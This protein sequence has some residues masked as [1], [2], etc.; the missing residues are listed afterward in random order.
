M[1][2]NVSIFVFLMSTLYLSTYSL[3]LNLKRRSRKEADKVTERS[4]TSDESSKLRSDLSD[5]HSSTK[6]REK[7]FLFGLIPHAEPEHVNNK[8]SINLEIES[9]L[10]PMNEESQ[11]E[12]LR[13]QRINPNLN[14]KA[15]SQ[16]TSNLSENQSDTLENV[17]DLELLNSDGGH[18]VTPHVEFGVSSK[19]QDDPSLTKE[20]DPHMLLHVLLA[21]NSS[22]SEDLE[23]G[24]PS[25][26]LVD[27][28]L[29]G[30]GIPS[31]E[32]SVES[33]SALNSSVQ[34]NGIDTIS[35]SIDIENEGVVDNHPVKNYSSNVAAVSKTN[36]LVGKLIKS[37]LRNNEEKQARIG[38]LYG[39]EIHRRRRRSVVPQPM[40]GYLDDPLNLQRSYRLRRRRDTAGVGGGMGVTG[41][42]LDRLAM[43]MR[44]AAQARREMRNGETVKIP[45]F[46]ATSEF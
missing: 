11:P 38:A 37:T 3:N 29:H 5:E 44:A 32:L 23:S 43:L 9:D 42:M 13:I 39:G 46:L 33:K 27:E 8:R 2:I 41:Q 7:R 22:V 6:N 24:G 28:N 45:T 19:P 4:S 16:E 31:Y 15:Q 1:Y 14:P 34:I 35:S 21:V 36:V 25:E 26:H 10:T 30:H 18:E 12:I 17:D 40:R 20:L